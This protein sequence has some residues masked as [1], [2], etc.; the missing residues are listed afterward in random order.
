MQVPLL[1]P[2][3]TSLPRQEMP[4]AETTE[5]T[6]KPLY[7]VGGMAALISVAVIPLAIVVFIA[8]PPAGFAPTA[9]NVIDW[10]KLF[11]NNP[12][13]GLLDLDLLMLVGEAVMILVYLALSVALRRVSPSLTAMALTIGLIGI[14]VYFTANQ[15][16][17]MLSLSN[18]YAAATTAAQ[19]SSLVAAGQALLAT[20]QGTPFDVGYVLGGIATLLISAVMLRSTLFNKATAYVGILLGILMLV[21][22][23][24]GTPGLIFGFASLV[25]TVIWDI[26][27]AR[28]LFQ[29][30]RSGSEAATKQN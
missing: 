4:A 20:Y 10:F 19:Q 22:A 5:A 18:Q 8:W 24:A 26:L 3:P 23:N 28:R 25:P 16:F 27:I 2:S 17:S 29:L 6:W 13:G 7:R 15:A 1:E 30:G 9:S 11:H 12:L 14:A 21:P